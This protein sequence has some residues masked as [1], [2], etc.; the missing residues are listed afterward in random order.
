MTNDTTL[1]YTRTYPE[2][3]YPRA[4]TTYVSVRLGGNTVVVRASN[5][6]SYVRF[7]AQNITARPP[8]DQIWT[9]A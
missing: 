6:P 1:I 7:A 9:R 3:A 4:G 2:V 8:V 5:T